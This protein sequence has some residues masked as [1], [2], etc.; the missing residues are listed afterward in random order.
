[1][2]QKQQPLAWQLAGIIEGFYGK[3]W[4]WDERAEVMRWCHERGMDTYVYAP[5]DD[6]KHRE[7]W[8]EPYGNGKLDGFA[9]LV[10]D[11]TLRVGFGISP[12]LSID[13]YADDDRASARW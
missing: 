1:M 2:P 9:R 5:K 6:P 8:R 13:C 12:G 3:P 4:T 10:D 7:R 11:K